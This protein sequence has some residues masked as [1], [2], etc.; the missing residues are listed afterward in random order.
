MPF[1]VGAG[2]A[3][4]IVPVCLTVPE[5][6]HPPPS[7]DGQWSSERPRP[8]AR[9]LAAPS[10]LVG[11]EEITRHEASNVICSSPDV[12]VLSVQVP[13][14]LAVHVPITWREPVT[15]ADGQPAPTNDR[16]SAPVTVRHV[17][18]TVQ[19]P[20]TSPP[21]GSTLEHADA[22]VG[23]FVPAPPPP[24]REPPFPIEPPLELPPLRVPPP[25]PALLS[26]LP[27]PPPLEL[28]LQPWVAMAPASTAADTSPKSLVR[29]KPPIGT[30]EWGAFL[31]WNLEATA[32]TMTLSPQETAST[33]WALRDPGAAA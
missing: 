4:P 9:R 26:V 17:D 25:L 27:A 7:A 6:L 5:Q 29:M 30:V 19:L 16:S 22:S 24:L 12:T 15:G 28:F 8:P 13:L 2:D 23:W 1:V 3:N 31:Q 10:Q 33:T 21:Q 20:T 18:V 32:Q 14:A 11:V